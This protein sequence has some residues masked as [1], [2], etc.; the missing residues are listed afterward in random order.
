MARQAR[1]AQALV[2]AWSLSFS[3]ALLLLA[4]LLSAQGATRQCFAWSWRPA[5]WDS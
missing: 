3:S 4:C 2:C 5:R 1:Q